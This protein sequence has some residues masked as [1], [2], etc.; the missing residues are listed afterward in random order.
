MKTGRTVTV[1]EHAG[2][3]FGVKRATD[4]LEETLA[5]ARAGEVVCTLGHLIHNEVYNRSLRERGVR[6]V[7]EADLPALAAR[8]RSERH[9]ES[10]E[11]PDQLIAAL[12]RVRR[13]KQ[14]AYEDW[15]D[16]L[17][18]QEDYRRYAGDYDAQSRALQAQIEM[19]RGA[20][21]EAPPSDWVDELLSAGRIPRLDRETVTETVAQIR[22]YRD[23]RLEIDYRISPAAGAYMEPGA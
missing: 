14:Q 22:V 5:N 9:R 11:D 7:E 16:G 19:L 10:H 13:R 12:E 21:S 6:T 23:R 17:I 8:E 18:T 3:C 1:A 2:F 4:R 20:S 15:R